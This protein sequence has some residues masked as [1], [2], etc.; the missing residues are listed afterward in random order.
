MG[1]RGVWINSAGRPA[2][3]SLRSEIRQVVR[4]GCLSLALAGLMTIPAWPQGAPKDLGSKTIEDLMNIEVTS[5]SKKEQKLSRT[6]AAIFVMTHEDIRRSGALNIPD[7][8]RMVPGVDV[9][10]VNGNSW[11]ISAR[12]LNDAFNDEVL[13]L[14]DGRNVYTPTF[15]GVFWELLDC[16]F[17]DIERIEVIRGPGGSI[18]GANAVNGVINIITKKAGETRGAM[19]VAG[20][21]NVDQAF[22]TSQ[23]G[24]QLGRGTDYRVYSKF[25]NHDELP[26]LNG[27]K[28]RDGSHLLRGGFRTDSTLSSKDT[29]MI[30]GDLFTG[31]ERNFVAFL[32]S[33]ASPVLL[34]TIIDSG[35]SGSFLQSVW[36]H[37]Y[38][39]GS[40]STLNFSYDYYDIADVFGPISEQ[41][42]TFNVEFQHHIAWGE[43]QDIVWG[44]GYSRSASQSE[45]S[46][47]VSLIPADLDI[48]VFSSF[49]QDEIALVPERFYLTVG[50][51]LEHNYYTGFNIMPSV[52][53]TYTPGKQHMFWMAISKAL[54]TPTGVDTAMRSNFPGAPAPDGHPTL[55]SLFGNPRL[56]SENLVAYEAGYRTT[57]S[58]RLSIDF[59]AYNS[60][61]KQ[62]TTNEPSTP[63]LETTP[64]PAHFV[65]PTTIQNLMYGEAHGLE[66][67]VNWRLTDRWSLSPGYA[68]ERLHMHVTGA[69]RDTESVAGAEGT[70]AHVH[71]QLRSHLELS[72]QLAWDAAAYF[73]D[74][75]IFQKVPSYTRLD[76]G[77]SWKTREGLTLS[78]V[79]QNLLRDH[80]V[81]F[82]ESAGDFGSTQ[83][84]RSAYVK[85]TWQ[86]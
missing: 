44:L 17:E 24:G 69:S 22:G 16:P 36:N 63:F 53:A 79:G 56:E 5:V 32:P 34:N 13:V 18:W 15:G 82:L 2:R 47:T 73:V 14:V 20:G 37:A 40:D 75:V 25:F 12:G 33:V 83:A 30:Q 41:R 52:R 80:H 29:L 81:E 66:I 11:A 64:L 84:K 9:T 46:L 76:T 4:R 39:N 61:F 43:R 70:D 31:R 23:Y 59:S 65:L 1:V 8:L 54:S 50:T 57:V 58:N 42:H 68:F 3:E 51:K 38:S 26:N 35:Q 7:L 48:Q 45:G 71:A 74:R 19:V 85:L 49:I 27:Q 86:F 21:G 6:A 67:A 78:V 62:L 72:R 55:V 28:G 10:Q 60:Q 77:L